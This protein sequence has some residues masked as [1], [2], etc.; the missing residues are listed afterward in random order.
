VNYQVNIVSDAEDDLFEIYTYILS[1]DSSH[2]AEY[3]LNEIEKVCASLE[4]LPQRRHV[5]PEL[6]RINVSHFLEV[7]FKPYRII[8]EIDGRK[9]FIHCILDGRR[10]LQDLLAK[11]LLR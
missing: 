3:V 6:S 4:Q 11:R 1:H 10:D 9:V 7:H 8:Y 2:N 5:P